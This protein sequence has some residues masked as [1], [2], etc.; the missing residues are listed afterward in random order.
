MAC[1]TAQWEKPRTGCR[2]LPSFSCY[3]PSFYP[4]Q[5]RQVMAKLIV[6]SNLFKGKPLKAAAY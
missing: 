6:R 2:L 4:L 5:G 3:G 1:L